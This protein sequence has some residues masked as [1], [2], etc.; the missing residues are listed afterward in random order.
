MGGYFILIPETSKVIRKHFKQP[1]IRIIGYL[2][3]FC[4]VFSISLSE[5]ENLYRN[6]ENSNVVKRFILKP[7]T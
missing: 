6:F 5:V 7:K 1:K 3:Y 2:N 4:F